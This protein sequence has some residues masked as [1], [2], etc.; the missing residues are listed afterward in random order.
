MTTL[1]AN[2]HSGAASHR[3]P[4]QMPDTPPTEKRSLAATIFVGN[5]GLR[6]G[7]SALLFMA[8]VVP[9]GLGASAL[10][11]TITHTSRNQALTPVQDLLRESTLLAVLF[12]ATL[13][14]ARIERRSVFSY[15]FHDERK[16]TRLVSGTLIGFLFIS[17]L[18]GILWATHVLVFDAQML[19]GVLAWKNALL[20]F[21]FFLVVA[22]FEEGLLRGYLQFTLTRG[23]TFWGAGAVLSVLFGLLH[24]SNP[25]E[26]PIGIFVVV[27]GGLVFVLSLKLTGSLWWIV[28]VHTGVGFA[29]GYFYGTANSGNTFQGRLYATHPVGNALWSGGTTGPEGSIYCMLA[30]LVMAAGMWLM[31]GRRAHPA[32]AV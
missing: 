29:Q 26:S 21:A 20:W 7:W 23:L 14:M 17:G 19:H 6:P 11:R 24:V 15:G 25:G 28:G 31:W 2:E 12:L 10:V 13:I 32:S 22:F 4:L 3:E 5:E 9:S 1:N 27:A 8:L 16:L 18:V 30:L